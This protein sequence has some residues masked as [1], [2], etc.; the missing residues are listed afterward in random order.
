MD[1]PSSKPDIMDVFR[2]LMIKERERE[3]T[4]IERRERIYTNIYLKIIAGKM[5]DMRKGEK[6]NE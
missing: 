6:K 3:K 5:A 4:D 2:A 1:P